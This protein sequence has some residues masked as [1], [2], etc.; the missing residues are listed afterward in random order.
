MAASHPLGKRKRNFSFV[1]LGL[2]QNDKKRISFHNSTADAPW[3]FQVE[4][5]GILKQVPRS[6]D[7]TSLMKSQLNCER[8]LS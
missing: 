7:P 6:L 4:L 3:V 1:R 2:E 8:Q 5:S